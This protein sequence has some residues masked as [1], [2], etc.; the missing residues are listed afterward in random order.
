MILYFKY[1]T[2]DVWSTGSRKASPVGCTEGA[3]VALADADAAGAG[4]SPYKKSSSSLLRVREAH[5]ST[6]IYEHG[7]GGDVSTCG[8]S[9]SSSPLTRVNT[10]SHNALMFPRLT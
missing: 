6:I 2:Q 9:R 5:D 7:Y 4:E 10:R 1:R 8:L 3:G